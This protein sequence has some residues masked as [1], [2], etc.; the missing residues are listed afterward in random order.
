LLLFL[1]RLGHYVGNE[2]KVPYDRHLLLAAMAPRPVCVVT[3]ELDREVVHADVTRA[4]EAAR[5]VYERHGASAALTQFSPESYNH[6]G[7]EMHVVVID[8]LQRVTQRQAG[9]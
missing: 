8:W 5:Q 3:P 4:V 6:F 1:P 2:P 7:P 9:S